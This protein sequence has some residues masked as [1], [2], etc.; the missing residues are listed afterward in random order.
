MIILILLSLVSKNITLSITFLSFMHH[1][2]PLWEKFKDS[3]DKND[4]HISTEDTQLSRRKKQSE[5]SDETRLLSG[6]I[7]IISKNQ[8]HTQEF[9]SF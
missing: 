5:R 3:K 9:P 1:L 8:F 4:E 2:F 6:I 7:K